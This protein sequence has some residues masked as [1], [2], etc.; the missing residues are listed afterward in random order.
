LKEIEPLWNIKVLRSQFTSN[1]PSIWFAIEREVTLGV[2]TQRRE[3]AQSCE[4]RVVREETD[5]VS[6]NRM[7]R[8]RRLD[9]EKLT[10]E[11]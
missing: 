10:A 4:V 1:S 9:D 5:D 2:Q 3:L 6:N 8:N 11:I 7:S